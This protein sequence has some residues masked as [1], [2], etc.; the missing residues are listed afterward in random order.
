MM[1]TFGLAFIVKQKTSTIFFEQIIITTNIA[2][3][4]SALEVTVSI[5]KQFI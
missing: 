4:I 5:S 3:H 1:E 2:M